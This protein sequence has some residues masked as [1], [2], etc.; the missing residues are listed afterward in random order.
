MVFSLGSRVVY[1][2]RKAFWRRLQ[3]IFDIGKEGIISL[4][5][6]SLIINGQLQKAIYY[7]K[8]KSHIYVRQLTSF[9]A[10]DRLCVCVGVSS[11][12]AS[13]WWSR[14]VC[15]ARMAQWEPHSAGHTNTHQALP[16][17]RRAQLARKPFNKTSVNLESF[18]H[19][20]LIVLTLVSL[21]ST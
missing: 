5:R 3:S 2:E 18:L 8:H 17:Q 6:R 11:F 19:R 10:A 15:R 7:V 9:W 21:N 1:E 4:Y 20:R 16:I 13:G 12:W 14:N